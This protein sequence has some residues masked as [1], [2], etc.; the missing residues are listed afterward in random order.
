MSYACRAQSVDRLIAKQPKYVWVPMASPRAAATIA[1]FDVKIHNDDCRQYIY[2]YNTSSTL[3]VPFAFGETDTSTPPQPNM[4]IYIL[5]LINMQYKNVTET[6]AYTVLICFTYTYNRIPYSYIC[7][8]TTLVHVLCQR[9]W[10][11]LLFVQYFLFIFFFLVLFMFRVPTSYT[12]HRAHYIVCGCGTCWIRTY[13]RVLF[14]HIFIVI[15]NVCLGTP[16]YLYFMGRT[17]RH[18]HHNQW[19]IIRT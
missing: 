16:F 3:Y 14:V 19:A 13:F 4:Q 8:C 6:S 5:I 11:C 18:R 7:I 12:R 15:T 1:T 17:I 10:K 9:I 2:I